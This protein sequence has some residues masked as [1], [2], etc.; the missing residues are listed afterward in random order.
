MNVLK[1][2]I[3]GGILVRGGRS[4]RQRERMQ[5]CFAFNLNSRAN[6]EHMKYVAE[7]LP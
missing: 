3:N 4:F 2:L 1:N 7:R 5:F 6:K